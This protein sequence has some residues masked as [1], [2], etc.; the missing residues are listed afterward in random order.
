LLPEQPSFQI[1]SRHQKS[2][3]KMDYPA[4]KTG[5]PAF[6]AKYEL[7]APENADLDTTVPHM[8]RE[9][10]M[11]ADPPVHIMKNMVFWT[12]KGFNKKPAW[13]KQALGSCVQVAQAVNA[14]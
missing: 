6:D 4:R 9:A 2:K 11:D 5:D 12:E 10:L 7:F 8:V 13:L 14:E 3:E 1:R